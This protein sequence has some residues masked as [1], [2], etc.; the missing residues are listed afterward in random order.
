M[1]GQLGYFARETLIS[2]RRNLLMTVAG[3]LTVTVSLLLLGGILLFQQ[4]VDHGTEKWKHGVEFEVFMKP[5]ATQQQI[6]GVRND[7][8]HD[9]RVRSAKFLSKEDAYQEFKR[10]FRDKPD[11]VTSVD[12][13]ALPAS[14]RVAPKDVKQ[15]KQLAEKYNTRP[16]VDE[17]QTADKAIK[18]LIDITNFLR[19]LFIAIATILIASS[20]FLIVNTIRLAT[21][22]RRREIEVMKL[23]G[24]SNWF[25][26]IPF[27][28]E[29]L[30][31]GA[32]GA[33]LAVSGVFALQYLLSQVDTSQGNF[34]RGYFV[35]TGDA[36]VISIG[37]LFGGAI[38]GAVGAGVGIRRFLRV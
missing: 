33:G 6:D 11:L 13:T 29:G 15:T 34:F 24:A 31:Q 19:Y 26:R 5:D 16:G 3:I 37:L 27:M 20:L 10:I 21:F 35:T 4:W 9:R 23:V 18:Q 7:L 8:D 32:V 30:A 38:I 14:F 28:F 12:A 2:L 36:A 25:V 1:F 17:S 22:A